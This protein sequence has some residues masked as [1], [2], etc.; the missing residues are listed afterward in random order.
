M[1]SFSIQPAPDHQPNERPPSESRELAEGLS[2]RNVLGALAVL[3]AVLPAAAAATSADPIFAAI[4]AHRR[5]VAVSD[6]AYAEAKRLRRLADETVGPSSIQVL[7]M[8]EPS[9][10]PG[11]HPY[12]EAGSIADIIEF[13][14]GD[15]N[16]ELRDHYLERWRERRAEREAI[17]GD[18]DEFTDGPAIAAWDVLDEFAKTV[19]TTLVG[20]LAMLTYAEELCDWE[21]E[22]FRDDPAVIISSLATAAKALIERQA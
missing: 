13:V 22:A 5:A 4:E 12:V 8:R 15:A 17:T 18:L 9:N 11:W 14:P 16:E 20:L 6:A 1:D 21:R 2:R 19:P 7:D 10:P 3:P